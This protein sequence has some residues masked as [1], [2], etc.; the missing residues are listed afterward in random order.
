MRRAETPL[1]HGPWPDADP[2]PDELELATL[3]D[4]YRSDWV[5]WR[6]MGPDR[7]PGAWCARRT[8]LERSPAGLTATTPEALRH[9]LKEADR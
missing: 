8:T 5:I 3:E 9:L 6:A 4:E 1:L 2:T 7:T